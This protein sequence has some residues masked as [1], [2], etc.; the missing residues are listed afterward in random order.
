MRSSDRQELALLRS[1]AVSENSRTVYLNSIVGFL[2]HLLNYE[3]DNDGEYTCPLTIEFKSLWESWTGT[4]H[5]KKK[6]L[7]EVLS[8]IT[9]IRVVKFSILNPGHFMA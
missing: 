8:E 2:V 9:P 4:L 1:S 3:L 5:A 6:R 7:M